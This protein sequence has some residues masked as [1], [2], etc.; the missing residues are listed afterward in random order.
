MIP[1]HS[2]P[3]QDVVITG[4]GVVSPIG[5]GVEEYWQ[6]L[7]DGKSG[8]CIRE[9]YSE[10]DFPLRIYAPV[11]D[12]EGKKFVKPRKAMKIMCRPIQF[13]F[14]AAAMAA[15]Q[16][17]ID[18]IECD[19][20]RYGTVFGSETFFADP[21]EVADVFRKC[22][23]DEHY[24]HDR[25]G[26]FAMRE[27]QPLWMLKYLPNMVTAHISIANDARGP[28]N[29]ICQ[30]EVS[31]LLALIE[32]AML[33]QRGVCD[34]V[35]V[36]G[37]GSQTS[38]SSVLYHGQLLL[39]NRIHEPEKAS[40]PFE[41][42]RDGLVVGEGSA[43]LV[44]ESKAHAAA[45][46]AKVL[47][48]VTGWSRNFALPES[49]LFGEVFQNNLKTTLEHSGLKAGDV[50]HVNAH[51]SS[52]P[53]ADVMEAKAIHATFGD[54][55]VIAQKSNFGLLGP[56]GPIVELIASI[57]ANQASLLPGTLNYEVPDKACP[58]NVVCKTKPINPGPV[59]KIAASENG[60]IVSLA[61]N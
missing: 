6:A 29:S 9:E 55:P 28:C 4:M 46:N 20:D 50:G 25:W 18:E 13:G 49:S 45:R 17:G 44:L 35:M 22:V 53:K 10:T 43:A 23:T 36:G 33:I 42:D 15:A 59:V 39:S 3:V 54:T 26:E 32:G 58:I 7:L 19:P 38:I 14:A 48:G 2:K 41:R 24:D 40:R 61:V 31:G 47:A 5:I 1:D 34:V 27:I 57:Q 12:F 21:M 8:V 52:V 11:K 56:A 60:Q 30:G 16:A 51:G 37:T